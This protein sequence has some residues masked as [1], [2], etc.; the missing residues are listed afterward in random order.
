MKNEFGDFD[1]TMCHTCEN[2]VYTPKNSGLKPECQ[3]C[4]ITKLEL[5]EKEKIDKQRQEDKV[6]SIKETE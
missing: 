5:L 1:K 2:T 6:I 3:N 4:Y